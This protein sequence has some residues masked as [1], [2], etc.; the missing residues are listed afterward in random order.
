V[1]EVNATNL[2]DSYLKLIREDL[3]NTQGLHETASIIA[4][5]CAVAIEASRVG[6]WFLSEDKT[7]LDCQTLFIRDE[8]RIEN[9]ATLD[10]GNS[11]DYFESLSKARII[12]TDDVSNDNHTLE[13]TRN[14]LQP[15]DI[16]SLLDAAICHLGNT[17]GVLRIEMTGEKRQWTQEEKMFVASAADLISNRV[18]VDQLA[19]SEAKHKAL[20]EATNE[21]VKPQ[22][23]S[24]QS[25]RMMD[26][27]RPL[28]P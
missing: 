17:K 26:S 13:I 16:Q 11:Y 18:V 10:I 21:V 7:S 24:H 14:Y 9:G 27:L 2:D 3:V 23:T 6:V 20:F 1:R 4:R 15:N 25:F 19:K 22:L 5:H 28:R 12:S 8:D